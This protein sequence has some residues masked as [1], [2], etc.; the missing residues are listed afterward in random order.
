MFPAT[1]A[2]GLALSGFANALW[3]V[4]ASETGL[5]APGRAQIV[6]IVIA[7]PVLAVLAPRLLRGFAIS[8]LMAQKT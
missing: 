5:S 4:L 8:K 7:G 2:L 3:I 1:F 6:C